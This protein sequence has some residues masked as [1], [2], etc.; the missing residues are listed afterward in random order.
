MTAVNGWMTTE[1]AGWLAKVTQGHGG[2]KKRSGVA[3]AACVRRGRLIQGRHLGGL[4]GPTDRPQGFT[5][6]VFFTVNCTF[7]YT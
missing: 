7:D 2:W 6:L 3:E 4:G 5:I 1:A